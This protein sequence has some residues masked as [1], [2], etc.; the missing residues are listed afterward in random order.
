MFLNE[1]L[2]RKCNDSKFCRVWQESLYELFVQEKVPWEWLTVRG[3]ITLPWPIQPLTFL[4]VSHVSWYPKRMEGTEAFKECCPG[5]GMCDPMELLKNWLVPEGK[6][7][8]LA[9]HSGG[10]LRQ[11]NL[12]AAIVLCQAELVV[13]KGVPVLITMGQVLPWTLL[14]AALLREL[15]PHSMAVLLPVSHTDKVTVNRSCSGPRPQPSSLL[16]WTVLTGPRPSQAYLLSLEFF[17]F[18]TI[19]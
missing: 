15:I 9:F 3:T 10:Q 2:I 13:G 7:L 17:C 16:L 8:P 1:Q 19:V 11:D 18:S 5:R 14:R 6:W 4:K 12:L